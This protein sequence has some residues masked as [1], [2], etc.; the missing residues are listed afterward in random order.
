[1]KVAALQL[2]PL[3]GLRQQRAGPLGDF[4]LGRDELAVPGYVERLAHDAVACLGCG[5]CDP[6]WPLDIEGERRMLTPPNR[7]VVCKPGFTPDALRAIYKAE[8]FGAGR[9]GQLSRPIQ[10]LQAWDITNKE[11]LI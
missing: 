4:V 6:R 8:T 1:M 9:G 2:G 11:R 5:G 3:P 10:P 7:A